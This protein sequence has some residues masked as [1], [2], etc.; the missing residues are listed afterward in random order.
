MTAQLPN[1]L[2]NCIWK[3]QFPL[4]NKRVAKL[5]KKYFSFWCT[6]FWLKDLLAKVA[7]L[8]YRYSLFTFYYISRSL[9]G[10]IKLKP[11][12]FI[13]YLKKEVETP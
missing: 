7:W 3:L 8:P 13:G 10:K 4:M 9:E 12:S 6:V 5:A 11:L 1:D 2:L